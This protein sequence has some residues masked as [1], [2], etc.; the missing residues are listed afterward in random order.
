MKIDRVICS[1]NDN[2]RTREV[3]AKRQRRTWVQTKTDRPHVQIAEY[4][5]PDSEVYE[6]YDL[7]NFPF[8]HL[9]VLD[10]RPHGSVSVYIY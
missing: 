1:S 8:S 10:S 4:P 2:N 6:I 5:I 9:H 7:Q 3:D